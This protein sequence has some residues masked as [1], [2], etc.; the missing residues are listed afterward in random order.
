MK[1]VELRRCYSGVGRPAFGHSVFLLVKLLSGLVR[2][3][4]RKLELGEAAAENSAGWRKTW[5]LKRT[6]SA[7]G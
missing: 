2:E 3:I 5:A 4:S 7:A 1:V 6:V